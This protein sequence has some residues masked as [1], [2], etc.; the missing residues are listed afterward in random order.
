MKEFIL[1][2]IPADVSKLDAD[3]LVILLL[4]TILMVGRNGS[5]V[6]RMLKT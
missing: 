3:T 5:I 4:G 6:K 2:S 1:N